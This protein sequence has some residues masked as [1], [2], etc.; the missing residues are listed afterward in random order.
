MSGIITLNHIIMDSFRT[1]LTDPLPI[2]ERGYI[3][4]G[5]VEP[6]IWFRMP[7]I[8][9]KF[10]L[11]TISVNSPVVESLGLGDAPT[12]HKTEYTQYFSGDD[13]ETEFTL[14]ITPE[15]VTAVY[16]PADTLQ[17]TDE[18]S[19]VDDKV[20]FVDIVPADGT[21]N[22]YIK[23]FSAVIDDLWYNYKITLPFTG[24]FFCDK[25]FVYILSGQKY[26]ER[27][28]IE[29]F[30]GYILSQWRNIKENICDNSDI[31]DVYDFKI[32][33]TKF[34]D[35]KGL[36][37]FAFEFYVNGLF[38]YKQSDIASV[39]RIIQI[40]LDVDADMSGAVDEEYVIE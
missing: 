3:S 35:K 10:P 33:D 39:Y 17:G 13:I 15:E 1:Y 19:V 9:T 2:S 37:S 28:A 38:I 7:N 16:Y 12:Q 32:T 25:D 6:W 18:Y 40:E 4:V 36:Y 24:T 34:D 8:I 26:S 31:L 29:Y 30:E 5:V 22:I 14:S 23:F 11:I 21:D 20:S 27:K